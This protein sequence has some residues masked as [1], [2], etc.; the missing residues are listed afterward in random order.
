MK[1][2]TAFFLL[3]VFTALFFH[4]SSPADEKVVF[5]VTADIQY[6]DCE[7]TGTRFYRASL[8]KLTDCVETLNAQKLSFSIQLGDLI[9]RDWQSFDTVL[10]IYRKLEMPAYHVLGNHDFAV[11]EENKKSIP[12]KLGMQNRYYDFRIKSWRFIVLDGN[13][14]SF[15]AN[16][17]GSEKWR[18]DDSLFRKLKEQNAPNAQV[19][20]GAVGVEQLQ[21]LESTLQKAKK[22]GERV[23]LFCHHP[24]FPLEMHTLW[25]GDE[26]RKV[27]ESAGCVAA[28][29]TGHNHQGGY[30]LY[31]GV[32]YLN[33]KGMVETPDQNAFAVIEAYPDSLKVTGYGREPDRVLLLK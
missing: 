27:I 5:G 22:A 32:H 15:Y 6:C 29:I 20:D 3:F 13:D 26:V 1:M 14:V 21:W 2:R 23:I 18:M 33:L 31:N 24:V 8:Q 12:E 4:C 9:D 25:N 17:E 11:A 16:E 10:A 28:F 7:P 19:W 30:A